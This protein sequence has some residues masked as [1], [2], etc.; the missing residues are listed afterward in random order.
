MIDVKIK[1][2]EVLDLLNEFLWF[3]KNINEVEK[4]VKCS[5]MKLTGKHG[6]YNHWT[7]DD[8]LKEII[9]KG[10]QHGGYPE[11]SRM[12]NLKTDQTAWHIGSNDFVSTSQSIQDRY[13]NANANLSSYFNVKHNA[14]CALYPPGGWISWHNNANAS[15]YNLIFTW[16][17]TGEG[18]FR[19]VDGKTGKTVI[20]KDV[21]GW[22]CK[23]GYFGSYRDPKEELV[24]HSAKTDCWRMTVSFI[25]DQGKHEM[26]KEFQE[27]VIEDISTE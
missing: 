18:D 22:Q 12:Y 19:Y 23:Y 26:S 17:E 3:V 5:A 13:L 21:P 24:Y 16:S 8:Y 1:N 27:M 2:P 25:F 10:T 20:M 6:S 14:L 15:A 7:G 4:V 9:A 11:C